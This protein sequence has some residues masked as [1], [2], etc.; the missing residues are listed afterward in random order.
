[1]Q[2]GLLGGYSRELDFNRYY[3]P[4]KLDLRGAEIITEEFGHRGGKGERLPEEIVISFVFNDGRF[5]RERKREREENALDGLE[6]S[7][8]SSRDSKEKRDFFRVLFFVS[9][10]LPLFHVR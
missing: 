8:S 7:S 3:R 6:K 10:P 1:M 4:W 2:V 9:Q 5:K